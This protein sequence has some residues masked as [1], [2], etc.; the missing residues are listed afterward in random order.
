MERRQL[1]ERLMSIE[2]EALVWGLWVSFSRSGLWHLPS[3]YPGR[4]VDAV[5]TI[6]GFQHPH[7]ASSLRSYPGLSAEA[8]TPQAILPSAWTCSLL[9]LG[10]DIH[11][12]SSLCGHLSVTCQLPV[13][14]LSVTW[15]CLPNS[16]GMAQGGEERRK[17]S[18][19]CWYIA[20]SMSFI[21]K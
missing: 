10:G 12:R 5:L 18:P 19:K 3:G 9:P 8:L 17:A 6:F 16:L 21:S 15:L 13:S 1:H 11:S 7:Q 14:D 2:L 20:I 4:L